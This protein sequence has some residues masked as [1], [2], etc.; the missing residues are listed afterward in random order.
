MAGKTMGSTPTK[1]S[2]YVVL[3]DDEPAYTGE[4][5]SDAKDWRRK[6]APP[7]GVRIKRADVDRSPA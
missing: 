6:N 7:E 1:V 4:T 2:V 3:I 5:Y